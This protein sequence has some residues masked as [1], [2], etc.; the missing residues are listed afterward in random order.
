MGDTKG[1]W[2]LFKLVLSKTGHVHHTVIYTVQCYTVAAFK[3]QSSTGTV[4]GASR[5]LKT[6]NPVIFHIL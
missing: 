4:L 6:A 1:V 2:D 3:G 5:V